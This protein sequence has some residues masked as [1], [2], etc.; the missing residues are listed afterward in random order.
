[1]LFVNQ[2]ISEDLFFNFAQE[3]VE[4]GGSYLGICAGAYFACDYIEFDKNGP[5]EVVG[6]RDLKFYPGKCER[7]PYVAFSSIIMSLFL[8]LVIT[9]YKLMTQ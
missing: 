8:F 7:F 9:W 3:F 1:M 4:N 5:L 2:Y 6:P